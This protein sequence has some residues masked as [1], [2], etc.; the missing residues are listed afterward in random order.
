MEKDKNIYYCSNC[1]EVKCV[2]CSA[3]QS[4]GELYCAE[5]IYYCGG[6]M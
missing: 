4:T 3:K 6:C 1:D 2:Y 5:C